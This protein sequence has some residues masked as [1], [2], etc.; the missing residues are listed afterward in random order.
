MAKQINK[1]V[2]S[3]ASVLKL[4]ENRVDYFPLSMFTVK[5]GYNLRMFDSASDQD[6]KL[7]LGQVIAAGRIKTPLV[8]RVV[9]G[10]IEIVEGHRRYFAACEAESSGAV[11]PFPN[12]PVR[13]APEGMTEVARTYDL[14]VSNSGKPL[15]PIER[16]IGVKRLL[17]EGEK[18][19]AVAAK[20]GIGKQWVMDLAR[21]AEMPDF[22]ARAVYAGN[23]KSTLAGEMAAESKTKGFDVAELW[24]K[25]S[26]KARESAKWDDTTGRYVWVVTQKILDPI[27]ADMGATMNK[28]RG[29]ARKPGGETNQTAP[30][31][32]PAA[33][34]KTGAE[35]PAPV[36]NGATI[37]GQANHGKV[38]GRVFYTV[39]GDGITILDAN[40]Q[41]LLIAEDSTTA[42]ATIADLSL[43]ARARGHGL[44]V[45]PLDAPA[46]HPAMTPEQIGV[47]KG[48]ASRA[49]AAKPVES[50]AAK[51]TPTD[52][53]TPAAKTPAAKGKP[54]RKPKVSQAA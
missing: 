11:K 36:A 14:F 52:A 3:T 18:P 43:V 27:L 40:K 37:T 17:T 32:T 7:F 4:D 45:R 19:S 8:C 35:M 33:A 28:S 16:A 9:D 12:L 42:L 41:R 13:G 26:A 46:K 6:D 20:C 51:L 15:S 53:I 49:E 47:A 23:V 48:A 29:A 44:T 22:L 30:A 38:D 24:A 54:G 10:K 31:A 50:S 5:E 39:A 21:M 34:T 2:P 1:L 25:A